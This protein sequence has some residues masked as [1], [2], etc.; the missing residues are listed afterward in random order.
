MIKVAK[1]MEEKE[2]KV[3][4]K[5][6]TKSQARQREEEEEQEAE[7][8]LQD[9][10]TTHNLDDQLLQLSENIFDEDKSVKLKQGRNMTELTWFWKKK[11]RIFA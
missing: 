8:E 1:D 4:C 9:N 6:E 5:V 10:P 2:E 3:T 7:Q 11:R